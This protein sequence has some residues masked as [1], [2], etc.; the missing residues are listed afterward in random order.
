MI[1]ISA[2][3]PL[4]S[5]SSHG[6]L[7]RLE[8]AVLP[9]PQ[10]GSGRRGDRHADAGAELAAEGGGEAAEGAGERVSPP[11]D[12]RGLQLAGQPAPLLLRRQHR[13]EAGPGGLVLQGA[14]PLLRHGHTQVS[15]L[16]A[17]G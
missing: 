3:L 12:R 15:A 1:I 2:S 11:Q 10:A 9:Q 17:N 7:V 8:R 16:K 6:L 4:S 14:A 13:R 5:G